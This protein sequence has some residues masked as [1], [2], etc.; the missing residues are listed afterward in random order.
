MKNYNCKNCNKV[1]LFRHS[2]K[3]IYCSIKCQSSDRQN[4]FIKA[5]LA[6]EETGI[7]VNGTK[8]SIKRYLLNEQNNKCACCGISEWN[9]KPIVLELEHK[10]GNSDNNR[11]ENLECL[12]PNCHSQTLTYKNRNKGNGRHARR[13]RYSLDKSY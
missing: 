10:D 1:S 8:L 11:P 12:C 5:W 6:G 3:N 4:T 2:K 9:N 7:G 13:V